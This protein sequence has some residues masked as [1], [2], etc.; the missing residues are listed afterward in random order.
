MALGSLVRHHTTP[1]STF[2][3]LHGSLFSYDVD[4]F[5]SIKIY[6]HVER[7]LKFPTGFQIDQFFD[8]IQLV[9]FFEF[10]QFPRLSNEHSVVQYYAEKS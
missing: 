10:S 7:F 4:N 1:L 6:S 2:L 5:K 9:A 3:N 8:D